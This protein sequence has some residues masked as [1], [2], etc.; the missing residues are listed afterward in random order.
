MTT[1]VTDRDDL[2]LVSPE[3]TL[4]GYEDDDDVDVAVSLAAIAD[5]TDCIYFEGALPS[6]S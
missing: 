4:R 6:R 2:E 3:E 1:T 5:A